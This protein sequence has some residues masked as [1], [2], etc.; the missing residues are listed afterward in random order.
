MATDSSEHRPR[1]VKIGEIADAYRIPDY[2]REENLRIFVHPGDLTIDGDMSL[3]WDAP[4]DAADSPL[5]WRKAV[6]CPDGERIDGLVVEG[7]LRLGGALINL[8]AGPMLL[9]GGHLAARTL[10]A[11]GSFIRILGN[12][13]IADTLLAHSNSGELHI[14]GTTT[15]PLLIGED[16]HYMTLGPCTS[17]IIFDAREAARDDW[18]YDDDADAYPV[19]EQL[20]PVLREGFGNWDDIMAALKSGK[21]VTKLVP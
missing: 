3:A 15:A 6:Q 4:S 13:D 11:G 5:D 9:V 19:P 1:I 20:K 21:P 14:G 10:V 7:D 18:E 2:H 12:V 16:N 8:W 17:P